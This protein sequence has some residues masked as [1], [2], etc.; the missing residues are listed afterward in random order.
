MTM[1]AVAPGSESARFLVRS[2]ALLLVM[3]A[4]VFGANFGYARFLAK[5]DDNARE[6]ASE[7]EVLSLRLDKYGQLA[8]AGDEDAFDEFQVVRSR[9][10]TI[11]QGLRQGSA[12]LG[13]TAHEDN[14]MEPGV[15]SALEVVVNVWSRMS[16]DADRIVNNR[17]QALTAVE[18]AES[19]NLRVPQ[20]S[21]Q[22]ADVLRG[23]S[24]DGSA[25]LQIN[26]AN[27]Q[28]VLINRMSQ[29]MSEILAGGDQ[30]VT[31]ADAL[32]RDA[33]VFGQ[34][35][36][37]LHDGDAGSGLVQVNNPRSAAALDRVVH[38]FADAQHEIDSF[39]Q[40]TGP[41]EEV[42]Q[43]AQAIAENSE[44]LLEAAYNLRHKFG[45]SFARVFPNDLITLAAGLLAALALVGLLS[46]VLAAQRSA[47]RSA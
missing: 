28:I 32:Q 22:L 29:R 47:L 37:G 10:D 42:Q 4:M 1:G 11:I 17:E 41:L 36:Q 27:R 19:F 14:S 2:C 8:V 33:A 18:I 38:L 9:I 13:V 40:A 43:S 39:M 24:D 26:L 12:Q 3:S 15:G 44:V 45:S 34:V 21:A 7:L 23:M 20:I 6:V 35:L 46:G 5:Q 25:P 30:A 31:A 16:A